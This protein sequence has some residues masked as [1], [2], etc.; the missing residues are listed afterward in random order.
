[1][2]KYIITVIVLSLLFVAV[3]TGNAQKF[4]WSAGTTGETSI[5]YVSVGILCETVNQK[6]DNIFMSPISYPKSLVGLKGLHEGEVHSMYASAQT[7]NN[8]VNE[9]GPFS[10]EV[11]KWTEPL[12]QLVWMNFESY[13]FLIRTEDADKYKSWS[14]LANAPIWPQMLGTNSFEIAKAIFGPDVLDIWDTL[15]I[16]NFESSHAADALKLKEVDAVWA[17]DAGGTVAG[18]AQE[19]IARTDCIML[20]AT[21][22]EIEQMM[23]AIPFIVKADFDPEVYKR[24]REDLILG[25]APKT[26]PA[27]GTIYLVRPDVPDEFVYEVTKIAYENAEEMKN[28]APIWASFAKNPWNMNYPL[29]KKAADSGIPVHPGAL[30][31]FREAG[32]DTEGLGLE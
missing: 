15:D 16:K 13:Y 7:I 23:K 11:Y 14:D 32:Y 17:Y 22:E 29:Y 8:V 9:I 24:Y 2:K 27:Q 3:M 18:F 12:N 21:D 5:N 30:R 31:Y 26:L 10:P 28:T 1:M 25:E 6:S 4:L 20:F 19:A